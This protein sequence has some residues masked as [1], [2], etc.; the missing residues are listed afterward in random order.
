M[1]LTAIAEGVL[2]WCTFFVIVQALYGT[3]YDWLT[4]RKKFGLLDHSL[5]IAFILL[6][7]TFWGML[8][9]INQGPLPAGTGG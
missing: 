3:C 4:N 6:L 1:G 9:A 2:Y 8:E 5:Y 7:Y